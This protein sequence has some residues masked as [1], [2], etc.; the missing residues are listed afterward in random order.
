MAEQQ[1]TQWL[2]DAY[3]AGIGQ[4]QN[5]ERYVRSFDAFPDI[6]SELKQHTIELRQQTDD[7]RACIQERGG[8]VPVGQ[9]SRM[10]ALPAGTVTFRDALI[11]DLLALYAS[12][13]FSYARF[14]AIA[15]AA[16]TLDADEVADICERI[17]EEE[18]AMAEW[19]EEQLPAIVTARITTP[20]NL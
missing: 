18:M 3:A 9:A 8:R 12:E 2:Q 4:M 19:I 16:R 20:G 10:A 14:C 6:R 15:E 11:A 1:L 7:I 13:Q 5:M 17:A